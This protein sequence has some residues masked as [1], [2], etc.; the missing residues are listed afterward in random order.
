MGPIKQL[1]RTPDLLD[2][3][4]GG[5]VL[6]LL[7]G[8]PRQPLGLHLCHSIATSDHSGTSYQRINADRETVWPPASDVLR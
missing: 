8:E 4:P 2:P 1:R 5:H 7:L 3:A 6:G